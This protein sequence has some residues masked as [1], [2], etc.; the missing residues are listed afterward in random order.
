MAGLTTYKMIPVEEHENKEDNSF[1]YSPLARVEEEFEGWCD[2][3]KLFKETNQERYR[4]ASKQEFGHLLMAIEDFFEEI[5]KHEP[6]AEEQR[7]LHRMM[8]N[9][10][11]A[12][13]SV[14]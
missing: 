7:E 5:T 4:I 1:L 9:V 8:A 12:N 6:D 13:S 3:K 14:L 10:T 2:Y 11:N